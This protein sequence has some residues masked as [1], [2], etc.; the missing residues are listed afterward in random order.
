MLKRASLEDSM[1]LGPFF[2]GIPWDFRRWGSPGATAST[3][4][5]NP[6]CSRTGVRSHTQGPA[7]RRTL[8]AKFLVI[9]ISW[10]RALG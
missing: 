2:P 8:M 7:S 4:E 6:T 9:L 5:Q 3:A 10:W 1:P